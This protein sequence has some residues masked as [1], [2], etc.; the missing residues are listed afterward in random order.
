MYMLDGATF[1]YAYETG[2]V[3]GSTAP[4]AVCFANNVVE[5]KNIDLDTTIYVADDDG[6]N[7]LVIEVY[8]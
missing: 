8:S 7:T 2:K 4:Y 3:A 6:L 1:R 5:L